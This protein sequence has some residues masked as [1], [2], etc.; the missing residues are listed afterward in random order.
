MNTDGTHRYEVVRQSGN[1]AFDSAVEN[2]L[3][4]AKHSAHASGPD[5]SG[6]IEHRVSGSRIERNPEGRNL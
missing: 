1:A 4:T 3:E 6:K 2:A 5:H